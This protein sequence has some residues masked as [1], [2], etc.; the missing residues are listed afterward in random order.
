[1]N[2][3]PNFTRQPEFQAFRSTISHPAALEFLFNLCSRC[4]IERK[5]ELHLPLEY[6]A[7][8]L[9]FSEELSPALV[10]DALVKYG[11]ISPIDGKSDW[12]HITIFAGN[13]SQLMACWTNGAKGGK[14]KNGGT[15]AGAPVT[16]PKP[17]APAVGTDEDTPF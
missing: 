7:P 4:Q 3:P 2:L 11:F 6:V 14:P 10:R 13:N 17:A 12:F 16:P 5:T 1:M 8:T 15:A 9:G